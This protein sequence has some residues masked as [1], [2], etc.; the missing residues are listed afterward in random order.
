MP[1]GPR[2]EEFQGMG[3]PPF[4]GFGEMQGQRPVGPLGVEAIES[5]ALI[6]GFD[7]NFAEDPYGEQIKAGFRFLA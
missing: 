1:L 6:K 3:E 7:L 4:T 2:R 5:P